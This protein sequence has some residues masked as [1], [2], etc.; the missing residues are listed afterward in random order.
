MMVIE[1]NDGIRSPLVPAA[2]VTRGID[3]DGRGDG[4]SSQ[5]LAKVMVA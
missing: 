4:C 1:R 5:M 3:L 2:V